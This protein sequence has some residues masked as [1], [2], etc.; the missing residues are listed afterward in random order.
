LHKISPFLDKPRGLDGAMAQDSASDFER[1]LAQAER[2]LNEA[3]ERQAASDE[4]LRVISSSPGELEPVFNAMLANATRICEAKLGTLVLRDGDELRVVAMH[5]APRAFEELR[6]RDPRVPSTV[7]R[8]YDTKQI[9]HCADLA[10]EEAYANLPLVRLA[11]ARS[12]VVVPLLKDDSL[13]GN[14]TIY[15]QE[16][17]PFTN[18]Q[19]DLLTSFANQ[20]VIAIENTRLLNE[21]RESLQQQTATADVLKI[22]SRSTFDLQAVLDTLVESAA[23][24]C[25]ADIVVL[26]RPRGENYH[27]E[28][29][30]GASSEYKEFVTAHP[31]AIDRGTGTGRAL[32]EGKIIHIPDVVA[33][34]DYTYTEGQKVGGYRTLLAFRCCEKERPSVSLACNARQCGRSPINRSS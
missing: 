22:I 24:L 9:I 1:R 20:A 31:A 34:T 12:A 33:D 7:R 17:R 21:L 27:F 3:L 13:I 4:V 10:A 5:G 30:F 8:M 16:V 29:I 6:Q 11:G 32:L 23:R 26:A 19:I 18:K 14:L 2:Q 15:R 28:A 25:E